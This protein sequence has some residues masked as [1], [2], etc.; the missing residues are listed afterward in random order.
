M[1]LDPSSVVF[2]VHDKEGGGGESSHTT[3][4][5]I[6]VVLKHLLVVILQMRVKEAPG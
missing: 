4:E 6:C 2:T 5:V 1:C 3:L